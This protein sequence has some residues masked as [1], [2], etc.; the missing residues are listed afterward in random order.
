[1]TLNEAYR[2]PTPTGHIPV[3]KNEVLALFSP[4]YPGR[5]LDM[6]FGGGGHTCALLEGHPHNTVV[7][8]DCDP[9]A[10]LR[11]KTVAERYAGRF[12]FVESFFDQA[13]AKLEQNFDGVL[14]DLGVSSF[15]FDTPERGF[16]FRADAPLDMRMNPNAGKPAWQLLEEADEATL[17]LIVR[18]LAEDPHWKGIVKKILEVRASG[19]LRTTQGLV[20]ALFAKVRPGRIHPATRLFMGLRIAVNHELERLERALPQA[21]ARLNAGGVLA[22]ISFH[23]GEDRIVKNFVQSLTRPRQTASAASLIKKVQAPTATECTAN[24]RARSAK[25]R[26]IA[27]RPLRPNTFPLC[28]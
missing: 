11:A 10:G 28:F 17:V 27:K 9:A 12:S 15:Q 24:P 7:G 16:S 6:T 2:V 18:D 20:T 26:A 23:S 1:M 13:D 14:M 22:V 21:Y 8:V 5:F 25:L 19:T 4:L 3:L